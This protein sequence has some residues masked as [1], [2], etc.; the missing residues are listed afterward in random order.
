M[1][2]V[3]YRIKINRKIKFILSTISTTSKSRAIMALVNCNLNV[4]TWDLS[5]ALHG[6]FNESRVQSVVHSKTIRK[7]VLETTFSCPL[8]LHTMC[9]A[10]VSKIDV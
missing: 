5:F 10:K 4:F 2:S 8:A 7:K 1:S 9:L 3:D 6:R